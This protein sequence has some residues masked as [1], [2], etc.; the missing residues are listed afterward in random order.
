M[1]AQAIQPGSGQMFDRIADRYDLL[2]RLLS[3]GI[4]RRW[5]RALL[6]AMPAEGR[7]LDLATGTADVALALARFRPGAQ[8]VG[9]DPSEGMLAVGVRKVAGSG[10][11]DRVT[12]QV[13]DAQALDFADDHFAGA[14][15]AF[16]IRNVPDR[17][18]GL[19]EMTRVTAPGGPVVVLEL[20]EPSG[21]VLAPLARWHVRQVVPRLGALLSGAAEYRYLQ[22]SVAAFPAPEAF[23]ELMQGAGLEDVQVQ[24]LTFGAAHLYVGRVPR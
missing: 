8:V 9:V 12:L 11:H 13:G 14:C 17:A 6:A 10:L 23:A 2:N 15:I 7:L 4:D 16:G 3:L 21:G 5:R 18:L 19:R 20:G 24:R 22:T 1:S